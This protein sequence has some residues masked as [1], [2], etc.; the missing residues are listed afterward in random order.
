MGTKS[1]LADG[2]EVT[3]EEGIQKMKDLDLDLFFETSAKTNANVK[4]MFLQTAQKV[5]EFH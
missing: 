4:E 2:R 3:Y 5:I 1:D